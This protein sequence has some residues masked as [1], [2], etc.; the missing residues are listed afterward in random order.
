VGIHASRFDHHKQFRGD[1]EIFIEDRED[2][3]EEAIK[4]ILSVLDIVAK[5]P[6]VEDSVGRRQ[7]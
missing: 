1:H 6:D 4:R 2:S 5:S 7:E 3:N